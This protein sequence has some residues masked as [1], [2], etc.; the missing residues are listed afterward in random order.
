MTISY[1]NLRLLPTQNAPADDRQLMTW[2]AG[3]NFARTTLGNLRTALVGSVQAQVDDIK[4]NGVP[5]VWPTARTLSLTGLVTGTSAAFTGSGN[6]SFATTIADAALSIAKTSGLQSALDGKLGASATAAAA[7]KLATTRAFSLTGVVTAAAVNFDGTG[8]LALSTAIA[9]NALAIA[10]TSGLQNALDAKA[11]LAAPVFTG[12]PYVDVNNGSTARFRV[13]PFNA[14]GISVES[15]NDAA[16]AHAPLNLQGSAITLNGQTAWHAGNFNP[17]GKLDASY[18]PQIYLD[19]GDLGASVDLNTLVSSGFYHQRLNSQAT[20]G[21]NYPVALA[22]K[23]EVYKSPAGDMIYQTYHVYQSARIFARAFYSN[24]WS[25]WSEFVT[26]GSFDPSQYAR[27][28]TNTSFNSVTVAGEYVTSGTGN[29]VLGTSNAQGQVLLRPK[30]AQDASVQFT[31]NYAGNAFIPEG[32]FAKIFVSANGADGEK[33]RVG[34]DISLWDVGIANTL[35]LRGQQDANAAQLQF[36][37]GGPALRRNS[38]WLWT[39]NEFHAATVTVG[40]DTDLLLYETGANNGSLGIRYGNAGANSYA[41]FSADGTLYAPDFAMSSDRRMKQNI[42]AFQFNGRLIP[43]Q[44]QWI[45]NGKWDIGFIAQEVRRKY[46]WLV[47][48]DDRGFWTLHYDKIT[49]VLAY[50]VNGLEDRMD[51]H[52]RELAKRDRKIATL[53]K[54]VSQLSKQMKQLLRQK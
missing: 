37:A 1:T 12:I 7:T 14:D 44:Y 46:P 18:L 10:K 33:Y 38:G 17:A 25:A 21:A 51:R 2:D 39:D 41:S 43:K 4:A 47:S 45:K 3:G 49:A 11:P 48:K 13:M 29:M 19:R 28:G 32:I 35:G 6:I 5:S 42:S 30:G 16:S 36:G 15:V 23:L 50:Q 26:T 9:D 40:A 24:A 20:N 8:N 52:D 31:F 27:L 34:D 54:Q 53:Q 22:G